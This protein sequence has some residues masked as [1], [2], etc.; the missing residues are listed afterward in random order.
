[1]PKIFIS[2]ISINKSLIGDQAENLL[3]PPHLDSVL[4]R[5]AKTENLNLNL[6]IVRL[7]NFVNSIQNEYACAVN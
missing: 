1:M 5:Q 6:K 4:F 7:E 2:V 3:E